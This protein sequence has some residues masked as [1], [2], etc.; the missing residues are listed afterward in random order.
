M[1]FDINLVIILAY[2][3]MVLFNGIYAGRNVRNLDDFATG[4]RSYTTFFI[5][6]TLSSSF[7]GGG[8]TTGL[9]EKVVTYGIVYVVALWGFSIKE[10][11][12]A[13]YIVPRMAHFK[14]A[15]SAGDIMGK[16]YGEKAKIFTGFASVLVCAGIAGAQFGAFGYILNVLMGIPHSQGILLAGLI[17]IFYSSMG[18]MKSVVANDTLHFV[19]LIVALPLVFLLGLRHVGG[20]DLLLETTPVDLTHISLLHLLTLTLSFFFGETLVPPYIQRLLIGKDLAHT[21]RGTF[22]SGILSFGFFVMI[23]LIGVM[24]QKI[25]PGVNP[26]LALASVINTVMPIG[27]KGLAVAG[28]MAVI[29][30]SADSF[31]NA[32]AIAASH[33]V[34]KPLTKSRS[35]VRELAVSR[36]ATVGIGLL[37]MMFALTCE[38]VL[39]I[40]L[41][42][43]T[44]WT[45]FILVPLVAGI[46]GIRRSE[47][48]F[49]WSAATGVGS[50]FVVSHLSA[51]DSVKFDAT[52]VGIALN[53]LVFFCFRP[54]IFTHSVAPR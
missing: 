16:L 46:M 14:D 39:D 36:T 21:Q 18:G 3:A 22:Y 19:V 52:L 45:P 32:A 53:A 11:L 25:N 17:V 15:I 29:M 27:L 13:F 42:S 35:G 48:V 23:G 40:L 54:K 50:V 7:I 34:I 38:S 10:V 6:A 37:G 44:F 4:N 49:W 47:T 9:A 5:F 30:S 51:F 1:N 24:A 31:L 28:M 26:N 33:D 41:H 12:I 2:F 43:Y 20:L 8:F